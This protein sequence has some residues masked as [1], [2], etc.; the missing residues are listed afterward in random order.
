MAAALLPCISPANASSP[1]APDRADLNRDGIVDEL[2]VAVLKDNWLQASSEG[3]LSGDGIVNFDD[4][5]MLAAAAR[6]A[7]R[8]AVSRSPAQI[9]LAPP[10]VETFVGEQLTIEVRMDFSTDPTIGGSFVVNFDPEALRYDGF[11]F[12][13][14]LGDDP[15]F[16][17]APDD[18]A[19]PG[20]VS[21][22]AFGNFNGVSGPAPVGTLTF[23]ALG[24][25]K[26]T[27]TPGDGT[28]TVGGPFL[29][30]QT[31]DVLEVTFSGATVMQGPPVGEA[32][33]EYN[34]TLA[35][36]GSLC[37]DYAAFTG[38]GDDTLA[39]STITGFAE[40][41][42]PAG[43]SFDS[44][45]VGRFR[46]TITNTELPGLI[47]DDQ[48]LAN[49]LQFESS[50][51]GPAD[52]MLT[53][54]GSRDPAGQLADGALELTILTG[55]L[56]GTILLFDLATGRLSGADGNLQGFGVFDGQGTPATAAAV[57][58]TVVDFGP[59]ND[60]LPDTFALTIANPSASPLTVG[61]I[62][63]GDPL[64]PPFAV[65]DDGCSD[66]VLAPLERCTAQL[67][68]DADAPAEYND[69]FDVPSDAAVNPLITVPVAGV[70]FGP[71]PIIEVQ[72]E[73]VHFPLA[74]VGQLTEARVT[75]SNAGV[76]TLTVSDVSMPAAPFS[77]LV[78]QCSQVPLQTDQSCHID[79]AFAPDATGTFAGT[80]NIESDDPLRPVVSVALNANALD[81]VPALSVTPET[82][83]FLL[84]AV[85][86]SPNS[87]VTVRNEQ[88][89][90]IVIEGIASAEPLSA[91]FSIVEVVSPCMAGMTLEPQDTCRVT[92][93]FAPESEGQF[94]DAFDIQ[95]NDPVLPSL[96]VPVAGEST[97]LPTCALSRTSVHFGETLFGEGRR[98]SVVV[99]N[100][101]AAA[102][103]VF[104]V[105]Q[106]NRLAPPFVIT[107]DGC[108]G[109]SLEQDADC[110]IEIGL[111]G[112][113]LGNFSDSFDLP[114][115]D[116]AFPLVTITVTGS[117]N[118]PGDRDGDLVLNHFDNCIDVDN[119]DQRDTDGDKIGNACD[120]D[121]D[122]SG[123]VNFVDLTMLLEQWLSTGNDLDADFNGDGVVNTIDLGL[124]RS[125]FYKT[126]GPSGTVSPGS[127]LP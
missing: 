106:A 74:T 37:E 115:N 51:I 71:S 87:S 44:D 38:L 97:E 113:Q 120:P 76:S 123:A 31:F 46:F 65:A 59:N 12:S 105:A 104:S 93:S 127:R 91:P 126:P 32:F 96:I 48:Q 80:L 58:P 40:I 64:A 53:G 29:S 23:T 1:A 43:A 116:P 57:W 18:V 84:T 68:F 111:T 103:E 67:S 112:D 8:A 121:L 20:L 27:V 14:D 92:V 33:D 52:A 62:G 66:S 94:A 75:I 26:S 117:V 30:A 9:W 55:A 4:L 78:D 125:R 70:W 98:E 72:P 109:R 35:V 2:D 86:S 16:R 77:V 42:V 25:D 56:D 54:S 60:G 22:I 45:D 11:V 108:S 122:N 114:S 90:P 99:S 69:S 19:E 82:V 21:F 118:P 34:G 15:A 85:G 6:P 102:L 13:D 81:S 7:G 24:G 83:E 10:V 17:F 124:L 63:K 79:L 5:A 73:S 100:L 28:N 36:C 3:D 101:G 49:P 119:A 41:D 110:A 88:V 39:H 61:T 95:S 50:V 89:V 107:T 47:D